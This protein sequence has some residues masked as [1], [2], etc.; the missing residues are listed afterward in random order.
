MQNQII[1]EGIVVSKTIKVITANGTLI[2]EFILEHQGDIEEFGKVRR[3][4][5]RVRVNAL[6][7]SLGQQ[8]E[9]LEVG[10]QVQVMGYL[11]RH[12]AANSIKNFEVII[13]AVALAK[14]NG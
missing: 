6:G 12:L 5:L 7:N 10:D 9:T 4:I 13:K 11:A 2:S 14:V 1:F 3:N 8:C